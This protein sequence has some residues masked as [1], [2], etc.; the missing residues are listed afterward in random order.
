MGDGNLQDCRLHPLYP[1]CAAPGASAVKARIASSM[2][3]VAIT[4]H[5]LQVNCLHGLPCQTLEHMAL[6]AITCSIRHFQGVT[7]QMCNTH[8]STASYDCSQHT[9]GLS[10]LSRRMLSG[11]TSMCRMEGC[12]PCSHISASTVS[13]AIRV[14]SHRG[15]GSAAAGADCADVNIIDGAGGADGAPGTPA[16][17]L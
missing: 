3:A 4:W 15:K 14:R 6:T 16:A 5:R 10:H 11:F 17:A 9:L 1:I 12:C 2:Q 8:Q 13:W 7:T